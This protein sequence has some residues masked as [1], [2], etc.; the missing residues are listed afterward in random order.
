MD[1]KHTAIRR[2]GEPR[3]GEPSGTFMCGNN[4]SNLTSFHVVTVLQDPSAT[5]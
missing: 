5:W 1:Q 3:I 4:M 2:E